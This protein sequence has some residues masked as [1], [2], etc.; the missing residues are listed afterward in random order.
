MTFMGTST[1]TPQRVTRYVMTAEWPFRAAQ[2][3]GVL[4]SARAA[5]A[6]TL[7][8]HST[9]G[10]IENKK[11]S[12]IEKPHQSRQRKKQRAQSTEHRAQSTEHKAQS[13][14]H[15]AQ[16]TEHRAQSTEQ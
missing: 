12:M 1:G 11:R 3:S 14:E 15:R 16:S 2:C 7:G 5:D 6:R 9:D 13:T 10:E 8:T 4:P